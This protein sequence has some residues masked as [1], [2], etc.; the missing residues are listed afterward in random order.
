MPGL[1][2]QVLGGWVGETPGNTSQSSNTTTVKVMKKKDLETTTDKQHKAVT[3]REEVCGP[4]VVSRT[5][6]GEGAIFFFF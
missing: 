1:V 5:G 4:R 2:V 3:I 6:E